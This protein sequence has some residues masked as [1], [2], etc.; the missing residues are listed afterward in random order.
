MCSYELEIKA[1]SRVLY[2]IE[3][4]IILYLTSIRAINMKDDNN[5]IYVM[6]RGNGC[7]TDMRIGN[8]I[9][10]NSSVSNSVNRLLIL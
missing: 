8:E 7:T 5:A 6:I 3:L 4:G 1:I 9:A 10:K 2:I